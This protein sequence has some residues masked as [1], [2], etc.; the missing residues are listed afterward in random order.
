MQTPN[1][2]EAVLFA[3]PRNAVAFLTPAPFLGV[4]GDF[5]GKLCLPLWQGDKV[6]LPWEAIASIPPQDFEKA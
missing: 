6:A 5:A 2:G 4:K 1:K 3:S